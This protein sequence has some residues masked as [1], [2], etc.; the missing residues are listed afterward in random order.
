MGVTESIFVDE[1]IHDGLGFVV[2]ALVVAD[3]DV[4]DRVARALSDN[5]FLPGIDEFKSGA[6]MAANRRMRAVRETILD[7]A[8]TRTRIA[9][10]ISSPTERSELGVEILRALGLL[11]RRNGLGQ[12]GLRV[13][14]DRGLFRS[15]AHAEVQIGK[16]IL[17]IPV[18]IEPEQDSK[19]RLGLQVA[20]AV[21][22]TVAQILRQEVVAQRKTV[23]V[24]PESGYVDGTEVEIGWAFLMSLR[25]ALF[26]RPQV[27]ADRGEEI[28]PDRNPVVIGPNDDPVEIG[29]HPQLLGWGVFVSDRVD[30]EVGAAAQAVFERIWL[31][32][33]H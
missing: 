20:D 17:P 8:A 27:Y 33:I 23:T 31:G 30:P 6:P 21:A 9:V 28:D 19:R 1:S 4:E 10:L 32:C 7:L 26:T 24:G 16:A 22:H 14:L 2:A 3:S 12:D 13:V 15:R 18:T 29:Q 25:Y 5:G 11:V